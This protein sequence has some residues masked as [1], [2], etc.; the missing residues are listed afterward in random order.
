MS[1][2][3]PD[4]EKAR[5]RHRGP[6]IGILAVLT[7]VAIILFALLTWTADEGRPPEDTGATI[8]GTGQAAGGS[9][10]AEAGGAGG[11]LP[12]GTSADPSA[13]GGT[14]PEA[15]DTEAAAEPPVARAPA[16]SGITPVAPIPPAS[17]ESP[18]PAN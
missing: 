7:F 1:A 16:D 12:E 14:A 8:G 11:A 13:N 9:T 6:L 10:A 4:L 5:R 3:E 17:S 2:S 15:V 18:A